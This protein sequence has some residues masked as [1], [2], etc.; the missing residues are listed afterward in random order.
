MSVYG[1]EEHNQGAERRENVFT[2]GMSNLRQDSH[3]QTDDLDFNLVGL[4][5]LLELNAAYPNPI[6]TNLPCNEHPLRDML[7]FLGDQ[8]I[9]EASGFGHQITKAGRL[10]VHTALAARPR[11]EAAS[12]DVF[13]PQTSAEASS[14]MLSIL[15]AHYDLRPEMA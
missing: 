8:G 7:R 5:L 1:T 12:S 11:D 9:I 6:D 15:R 10:S 13:R 3:A 2:E 4:E 14:I